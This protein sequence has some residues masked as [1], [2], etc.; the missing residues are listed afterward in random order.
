MYSQYKYL[1]SH[2]TINPKWTENVLKLYPRAR[3]NSMFQKASMTGMGFICYPVIFYFLA[4][5]KYLFYGPKEEVHFESNSYNIFQI[6]RNIC[7][8]A[9]IFL[10]DELTGSWIPKLLYG[11]KDISIP[12]DFVIRKALFVFLLCWHFNS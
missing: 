8:I 4:Y 2:V 10:Y 11:S 12:A 1:E 7:S 9:I 6:F 5:L 3:E